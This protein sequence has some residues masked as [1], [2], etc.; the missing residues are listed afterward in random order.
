MAGEEAPKPGPGTPEAG[1]ARLLNDP[2]KQISLYNLIASIGLAG[3]PAWIWK[4]S[5]LIEAL[6]LWKLFILT[7]PM[8]VSVAILA[9]YAIT[10][11]K[12]SPVQVVGVI[13][14]PGFLT[15][16]F[17]IFGGQQLNS[18]FLQKVPPTCLRL[19][20]GNLCVA[21]APEPVPWYD[22]PGRLVATYWDIYGPWEFL[23]SIACGIGIALLMRTWARQLAAKAKAMADQKKPEGA[24]TA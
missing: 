22:Q 24:A 9:G 17:G 11:T 21:S 1:G 15:W 6:P 13:L 4:E 2:K 10:H 8:T 16:T 14:V 3:L 5:R 18:V 23:A 7:A 20:P 19:A 12:I